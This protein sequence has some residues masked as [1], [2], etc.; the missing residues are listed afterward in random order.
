MVECV[1]AFAAFELIGLGQDSVVDFP[2][3][4]V[5]VLADAPPEQ[6]ALIMQ[7]TAGSL[8]VDCEYCH[9]AEAWHLDDQPAKRTARDMM[10]MLGS[11]SETYFETLEVPSCWTCHRGSTI[12]QYEPNLESDPLVAP[13]PGAPL[14]FVPAGV[15]SEEIRPSSEVYE[16]VQ[17]Y[18]ELPANELRGVME[19]YS[20]ALGTGCDHCH[21]EGD[22]GSD[23]LLTKLIAGRMFEIEVGMEREFFSSRDALSCWTCHRG[24]VTPEM[25]L[26]TDR[27]PSR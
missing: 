6:L 15:F 14:V 7:A 19:A 23:Q 9:D 17:H 16:N 21:V 27:M 8:G 12:P 5:Q 22:W 26:P 11:V 25:S 3:Q 4:N 2:Y 20:R 13:N 18:G 24:Q 1:L 10:R